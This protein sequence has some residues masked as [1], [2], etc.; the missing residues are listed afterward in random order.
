MKRL[1]QIAL[2]LTIVFA[3]ASPILAAE[4]PARKKAQ[5][6]YKDGNF[7]EAYEAFAKLA[8]NIKTDHK[9]VGGDLN[10]AVSALQRLNRRNETDALREKIIKVHAKNWRLLHTAANSYLHDTHY[11]YII[12]GEYHRG[13]HRGGGKYANSYE[14]DRVR[15]LQLMVQAIPLTKKD[16]DHAAVGAF[17]MAL[18][19]MMMGN[20]GYAGAW[21]LQYKTDISKLPDYEVGYYYGYG[22]H[23]GGSRGA[24]V[25]K[26]D[27]PIY[28]KRPKTWDAAKSDGQRWRWA[29]LQAVEF[30]PPLREAVDYKFAS[31]LKAQFGVETMGRYGRYFG[32]WRQPRPRDDGKKDTSGTYE[33]HT[34]GEDETIAKLAIGVRRFK[35]PDEYNY[36]L[37]FKRLSKGKGNW[38]R[39]SM[40]QLCS[41]F[42]NRRQYPKAANYWRQNIDRFGDDSNKSKAKRLKQIVD[43]WGVFE[44][45]MTQPSGKGATVEFRFRNGKQVHFEAHSI[46]IEKLLADVKA[47]IKSNPQKGGWR[48][49]QISNIGYRLMKGDDKKYVDKKV[50]AWDL[51]VKPRPGHFDK[52]ITV[53]TPLQKAGAYLLTARMANG[54]LSRIIIWVADTAIVKKPLN[55]KTWYYVADAV[56]GKPIA[57]ANVEFFGWYRKYVGKRGQRKY[58]TQTKNFSEFTSADGQIIL[59]PHQMP[60][61]F[62]WLAIARTDAG[63]MAFLGFSRVWYG[64]YYDREYNQ[65]KTFVMT[66]RPVYRPKQKVNFKFWINTAKYD[67]E[68]KSEFAGQTFQVRIHNP[69]GEKLLEKSVKLDD[70]G[71]AAGDLS[72]KDDAT[73][74]MYSIQIRQGTRYY[75][76]GRFRVEEYK[77]PEFEVKIEAPKEPVQLGEKVTATVEAKYYFGAPVTDAKVKYKVMRTEHSASWYPWTRWD[78]LFDSGYWWYGYD[79]SWYPGWKHW[80]CRRPIWPWWGWRPTPQPEVVAENEVR[81]GKD[82]KIKIA[83][84]TA[85][86]K[87]I[88]GDRDHKYSITAEVTDKSRRTIVGTGQ[89]LVSR[90]PFKVYAWVGQGHYRVG[91]V[92]QASFQARRLDAKGVKG[93]GRLKLMKISYPKGKP[94]ETQVQQWKLDTDED[95][96]A[97]IQIKADTPG[98]YRLSYTLTDAKK[99]AIEGG[100]VFVIWGAGDTG[101]NYRFNDIELVA[102]KQTYQPGEKVK[103]RIN[104]S[105][106]GSTVLLF[107]R[108]SNGVYLAPKIFRLKGRSV[109]EQVEV[110]KKD[111]PNFFVEA[112]TVADGKVFREVR[113][114]VVPPEKRV[115]DVKIFPSKK[116]YKPGEKA[117]VKIQLIAANGE[118]FSGSTVLTMYDKAVEYIS[119]G[120]NIAKIKDFFWK[121]KRHHNAR[122]ETSLSKS[123]RNLLKTGEIGMAFLGVFGRSVADE[124]GPG[125]GGRGHGGGGIDAVADAGGAELENGLKAAGAATGFGEGSARPAASM[126]KRKGESRR[127]RANADQNGGQGPAMVEPTVRTKFADTAFWASA[128]T[129]GKDGF[130]EIE[131]TMPENLTTWKTVVWAMGFGTRVGE[132][133]VEVVTTKNLIVRLQAPRFF[134]QKDEVVLSANVHN[135][136]KKA[137]KVDVSLLMAGGCME[138]MKGQKALQTVE[139]PAG[140]EKR[141]NWRVRITKEGD[142]KITMKALTDEESDAM[143]MDFPVFVHGMLKTDSFSGVIRPNKKSGKFEITVPKQRRPEESRLEIRYSPTLAGAMVDA[144]PYVVEYPYGCTEQTLNRFLPTVITQKVLQNMGLDL[145]EIKKKRTNLN[146]QEIGDDVKRAADWKRLAGRKRWNGK[147]WVNRNPVFDKGQVDRMVKAGLQRLTNMQNS[148]GGWGWWSGWREHSY[149]HTTA[150]VVHGLQ[151]ARANDVAVVPGVIKK[152]VEWLK[153]YQARQ[154]QLLI[155]FEEKKKNALKKQFA[156]NLDALVYMV[157]VDEKV[158]NVEMRKRI[159]R[160]RN[161][162]S[163]YAKAMFGISC[164]KVGD[165][166]KRDMLKRNVEQYLQQDDENQSA[167]LKLPNGGWWWRWY[168]SEMEAHA[169][170]LK[171]LCLTEPKSK[172]ASRLVKYIINNR[173]HATYWNST[174]DTAYVIEA[175]ADYIKAAGEDKPDMTVSI[176][177]DGKKHKTVKINKD[178]IFSFD[179]KLVLLGKKVTTGKHT[180]ELKKE[181]KGPLYFN[182]YLTNFTLEDHI[183]RAGLEIKVNRKYYKLVK[184][185]KKIKVEGSRGQAV[186]QKVEKYERKELKN[187]DTLKSGDLVEIELTMESKNDYEYIMFEDMKASGFEPVAL[188]S[189]YSANGMGAYMELRDERVTFFVRRLARGKHSLS[190]RMRAEI[191]GKFSALP[192]KASAMYAPE[193]KANSD[194]IK[195]KIVD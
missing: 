57:K 171:L 38:A 170:Y 41:M 27:E 113:Q 35:L 59:G 165:T 139:I 195:L 89:I 58:D 126:A 97:S 2:S 178:N 85:L 120:S 23:G 150:V 47:Y 98:Q 40:Y 88:H 130:A 70:F 167:W 61:N 22:R 45:I 55:G 25:D 103:L 147:Q 148:D 108:P 19:D 180:V 14:R 26:N 52:R 76:G 81:V 34:L 53:A 43:N 20:R 187:L 125:G 138:L 83:I 63:R 9:A 37:I 48:E 121:W 77:K 79:Y 36:I 7:K 4:N 157:L 164:H 115:L 100:Y 117:K 11:G 68:G 39:N 110:I 105:R 82:G 151:I 136:L 186:D 109:G 65:R 118:P 159:Y 141:V 104:T 46:K 74:G 107:V 3:A 116:K 72:L 189:G 194:E 149:P 62:S 112:L 123:G 90:K 64:R 16:G 135:Y 18:A 94:V 163:V 33:L 78:W 146:A 10:M 156:D 168:G 131:L 66:D 193:L 162:I 49:T 134:V 95:G 145:D 184:V 17:Y 93:S 8:L 161:H 5:K 132:G 73:L 102:D 153:R 13:H 84:D 91:E 142:A 154:L 124:P 31:F 181:G 160:D 190:Y 169:Y 42:E 54:N 101:G 50:A 6:L 44:P 106:R 67:I 133:S 28:H 172:K 111:M 179:N 60:N 29:L 24:P 177:V 12:S 122:H 114:I 188:R 174:R 15:A 69:K 192:T 30:S 87:A 32:S 144:L 155:N 152:G 176:V 92:V 143:A 71:G 56:S 99:H 129:T 75:G 140:G 127:S 21:R 183:T 185:D 80:G 137:K 51:D 119:G 86:A 182:A 158:D 173:R 191:P 175:F 1:T 128:L 166:E 96:K